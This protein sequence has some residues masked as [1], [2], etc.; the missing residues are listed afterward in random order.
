VNDNPR[1]EL[2]RALSHGLSGLASGVGDTDEVLAGMRPRL[3]RALTR[4]RATRIGGAALVLVLAGT[5]VAF[6]AA[7]GSSHKLNVSA[8]TTTA[9]STI[10]ER[11]HHRTATTT[12]TQLFTTQTIPT[13]LPLPTITAPVVTVPS[14]PVTAKRSNRPPATITTTTTVPS[15]AADHTY[16]SVGG[17][18]IVRFANGNLSLVS[19]TPANG[20]TAVLAWNLPND[21]AVRFTGSE[22][23]FTMHARVENGKLVETT[24]E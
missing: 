7:G 19:Y 17:T 3:Q 12:T 5:G 10:P 9:P 18:L 20:Y 21:V 14:P 8:G 6:L 4:H 1:D 11:R 15:T 2:D 13:N 24:D 23:V 22:G 16:S